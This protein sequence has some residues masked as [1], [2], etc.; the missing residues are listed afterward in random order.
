MLSCAVKS[1]KIDLGW[2]GFLYEANRHLPLQRFDSNKTTS[3]MPKRKEQE[4][5]SFKDVYEFC[6]ELIKK[7]DRLAAVIAPDYPDAERVR[8][9]ICDVLK[10]VETY[11][12][13]RKWVTF[14]SG[15]EY[16]TTQEIRS[17]SI[18]FYSF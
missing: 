14:C 10:T 3:I 11:E 4:A 6:S 9:E 2:A 16:V 15:A 18:F 12:V 5:L 1:N 17:V 8:E 7:G 13:V